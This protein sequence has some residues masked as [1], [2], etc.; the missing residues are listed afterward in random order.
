LAKTGRFKHQSIARKKS[1]TIQL[2]TAV[3]GEF[4]MYDL[5]ST[6]LRE[7]ID[8]LDAALLTEPECRLEVAANPDE[9]DNGLRLN[10]WA[11]Y[12]RAA[13]LSK[14]NGKKTPI[15][16][17]AVLRG[18]THYA[19][20]KTNYLENP[21][22]LAW[23]LSPPKSL[24]IQQEETLHQSMR[25]MR[26]LIRTIEFFDTIETVETE[27]STGNVKR[28]VVRKFNA[29]AADTVTKIT[30]LLSNRVQ[31]TLLNRHAIMASHVPP[32]AAEKVNPVL[33]PREDLEKRL[34]ALNE[35]ID[36]EVTED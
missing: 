33:P 20:F 21:G 32:P 8:R 25:R 14:V 18:V 24:A 5:V 6:K 9:T 29:K 16:L 22:K 15:D 36:A 30:E 13:D 4:S 7:A 23:L 2:I 12:Y 3:E 11:E 1:E 35:T 19:Y 26:D 17:G 28:R 10:F 27:K 34:K 31:G